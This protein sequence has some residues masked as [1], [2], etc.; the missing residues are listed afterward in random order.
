MKSEAFQSSHP[1]TPTLPL[2]S[3]TPEC[4][5]LSPPQGSSFVHKPSLSPIAPR[6]HRRI[7]MSMTQHLFRIL[8]TCRGQAFHL[9]LCS[10]LLTAAALS[11]NFPG[12]AFISIWAPL[13]G[14]K[15]DN[16]WM[17]L[18][19]HGTYFPFPFPFQILT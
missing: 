2:F 9:F 7:L 12:F 16:Q 5:F 11:S 17:V 14:T 1:N 6:I 10:L 15:S 19:N 8:H 3:P 4:I 18:Q 13:N